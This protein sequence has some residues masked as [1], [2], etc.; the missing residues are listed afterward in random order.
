MT[1]LELVIKAKQETDA[2]FKALIGNLDNAQKETQKVNKGL[3]QLAGEG[4]TALNNA[5]SGMAGKLGG[6]GSALTS[7]GPA[8]MAAAAGLGATVGA[9]AAVGAVI[10]DSTRR[11]MEY[12]DNMAALADR[13]G[14]STRALQAFEVQAKLGNSS[15]DG[16]VAA[17]N[18]MQLAMVNGS[19]AF[20]K[21]GLDINTLKAMD[22]DKAFT[23]VAKAIE[24]IADPA[25]RAAA[26]VAVFG[27][28]ANELA[29]TLKAAAQGAGEL[30][31]ALSD[32][33]L[34]AAAELQDQADLLDK[35]WERVILQ[36][37]ASIAQ[38]P[39]MGRA[40]EDITQ[41]VVKLA[42]TVAENTPTIVAI[43]NAIVT[44]ARIA[45]AA[46]KAAVESNVTGGLVAFKRFQDEVEQ[47]K[48]DALFGDVMGGAASTG[49]KKVGAFAGAAADAA[50]KEALRAQK[51]READHKA[52]L[53]RQ[54]KEEQR[55][56]ELVIRESWRL[57]NEVEKVQQAITDNIVK[58]I[59]RRALEEQAA[60]E[61]NLARA[62]E[63]ANEMAAAMAEAG[64]HAF[65]GWADGL[66][67]AIDIMD[68]LGISAESGLGKI[69]GLMAGTADMIAAAAQ[70]G[71]LTIADLVNQ[72]SQIFKSGS[73]LGGAASGAMTGFAVG[74]PIGA[75]IGALAGGLLGLFGKAKAAREE[76]NRLRNEFLQSVGGMAALQAKAKEAGIALDAMLKAK[77]AQQLQAAIA[78]I[79]G[80]LD[81]WAEGQDKIKAAMAEYGI[82]V[83]E[84]GPRF[85]Q[86]ELDKKA[87]EV[88]EAFE[89]LRLASGD[90]SAMAEK[91]GPKVLELVAQ[92]K[93]A[94]LAIPEA[95]RPVLEAMLKNGDLV[96]ENGEAY[97]SLEDA[98][99]KF[100]ES[101]TEAM[102]GMMEQVQRL[103]EVLARGF[104]VPVNFNYN[105]APGGGSSPEA[106]GGHGNPG[107]Y[108]GEFPGNAYGGFYP[109][110]Q[111]SLAWMGESG[112]ARSQ[113]EFALPKGML[114]Q[115]LAQASSMGAAQAMAMSAGSGGGSGPT[116]L[117]VDRQVLARSTADGYRSGA[118]SIPAAAI[119]GGRGSLRGQM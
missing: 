118:A 72:A 6:L 4:A 106:G 51:R 83:S 27:K 46:F 62:R 70:R 18:K 10:V 15:L 31:G 117:M 107:H 95:M 37:G 71:F 36:F 57:E 34:G 81:L 13:T 74:G 9:L 91:M 86:Q 104:N 7:M 94:G 23:E 77:S 50:A 21:L 22:P 101:M 80:Q 99:I 82:S 69:A 53:E 111:P 93:A 110:G 66:H 14:L 113:G 109:P 112:P 102:K 78:G 68:S 92:Y 89:V 115:L 85:A 30:G 56:A 41:M 96:D 33:A 100:A 88:A 2:A 54:Q 55:Y 32:E 19:T 105:N 59:L 75:G 116:I 98:G 65:D 17:V 16:V 29:G 49:I 25:E 114:Q 79:K 44:H 84:M 97:A 67:Q 87:A 26:R 35:A 5:A 119:R 40:L 39:E 38:S 48:L 28:S 73:V 61:S 103:V 64:Q 45:M 12:G 47:I 63:S 42:Q 60:N 3:Q 58:E 108:G 52:S 1:P 24:S 43:F 76:M 11:A 8:G 20:Q 90:A